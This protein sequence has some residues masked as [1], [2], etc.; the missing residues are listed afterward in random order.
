MVASKVKRDPQQVHRARMETVTRV[1]VYAWLFVAMFIILFPLLWILSTSLKGEAEVYRWPP[2]LIPDSPNFGAYSSI[3]ALKNFSRLE[4]DRCVF[5]QHATL[6]CPR[7]LG[8]LW[9]FAFPVSRQQAPAV[10]VP[11]DPDG[12]CDTSPVA[13]F[14]PDE[15]IEFAE[16]LH[17]PGPS[18]HLIFFALLYLDA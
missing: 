2:T 16:H 5:N 10:S 6:G 1:L 3:W 18:L 8:R 4:F 14:Y 17:F 13:L 9:V 15:A 7:L 12:A 11:G